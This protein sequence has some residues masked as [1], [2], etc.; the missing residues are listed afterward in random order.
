VRIEGDYAGEDCDV[1]VALHARRSHPSVAR[2]R[3]E[4]PDAPLVVALTG[5]DLYHDLKT[6]KSAERSLGLASALIVLQPR[7]RMA[8]P[9]AFRSKTHVVWQSVPAPRKRP[10]PREDVFEISVLAHLRPVKDPFRTA[11]AARLLP[12][13]SRIAITHLGGAIEKGMEA[14]ALAEQV[15]NPRYSW[16]GARSHQEAMRVLARSRA[17]VVSSRLEGGANV[18]TE[19]LACG[20]PVLSSRIEGSL[21]ILG[22]DYPGYF[23]VGDTRALAALLK[24]MEG[25]QSFYAHL[26]RLCRKLA[27]LAAPE[28]ERRS[29]ARLLRELPI[30]TGKS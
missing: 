15:R 25:D 30:R 26:R 29:W 14:R 8:L 10:R 17:L 22:A 9:K 2:F 3:Q 1:L 23:P 24:R 4:R 6:S 28:R 27:P 7:G 21:G 16:L 20:V 19:A 13:S 12:P 11:L 5:T 18:V